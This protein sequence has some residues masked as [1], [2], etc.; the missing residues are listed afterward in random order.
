M[1][2]L[3][4]FYAIASFISIFITAALL[5]LFYRQV[6][7]QWVTKVAERGNLALAHTTLNAVRPQLVDYLKARPKST[8]L[9]SGTPEFPPELAAAIK[10]LTVDTAVVT[11]KIFDRNGVIAYS[12]KAE[13]I[14]TDREDNAGFTSALRGE[15]VSDLVYRDAF[16]FFDKV[17]ES[18]NL[19]QTYIPIRIKSGQ[20]I[21]GVFEIYTDVNELVRENARMLVIFLV[22]AESMLAIL[23]AVLV[24]V[25]RRARNVIEAQQQTIQERTSALETL[26]RRLMKSEEVKK[27]KIA[28]DL[29][30]GLAQTLSAIKANVESSRLRIE[31][32]DEHTKSLDSIVPVIQSAIQEVRSIATELRPS[33]LD[34]LGLIS[35]LNW[36]CREFSRLHPGMQVE[37]EIELREEEIP[38]SL[39]IVIFRII[40]KTF[41]NV[42]QHSPTDR[43][44]IVLGMEDGAVSLIIYDTPTAQSERPELLTDPHLRFA[45]MRERTTL[46]YGEFSVIRNRHGGVTLHAVW[47]VEIRKT[48]EQV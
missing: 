37:R 7:I 30:E 38:H 2:K 5:T 31:T 39:K 24:L 42:A 13:Q 32:D 20:P 4:R 1:F 19:L 10:R 16:N 28:T 6:T 25:V 48:A 43:I 29:H 47:P 41:E 21:L 9:G 34:D 40:E 33:S 44:A 23:Y 22:G 17:T 26:T 11:F 8:E 36:Y 35:T 18:D 14:G 27:K 15:V 46:S 12:T 45:E 3:L